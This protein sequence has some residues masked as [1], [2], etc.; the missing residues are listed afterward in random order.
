MPLIL[1]QRPPK[2]FYDFCDTL[3]ILSSFWILLKMG[4]HKAVIFMLITCVWVPGYRGQVPRRRAYLTARRAGHKNI[5][6]AG[7]VGF[8]PPSSEPGREPR[9]HFTATPFNY[10]VPGARG[11]AHIHEGPGHSL[12]NRTLNRIRQMLPTKRK[13][14][15]QRKLFFSLQSADESQ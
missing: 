10:S 14:Q 5:L 3:Q 8:S 2:S 4:K 1:R 11:R 15:D 13:C 7:F 6:L 12:I 9:S